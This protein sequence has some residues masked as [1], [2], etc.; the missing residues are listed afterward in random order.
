MSIIIN[1]NYEPTSSAAIAELVNKFA[2]TDTSNHFTGSQYL[3]D[4]Y[5]FEGSARKTVF[6]KGIFFANQLINDGDIIH[7]A[8]YY[9]PINLIKHTDTYLTTDN[10]VGRFYAPFDMTIRNL[11][12]VIKEF[13]GS[14]YVEILNLNTNLFVQVEITGVIS[15]NTINTLLA[16][17]NDPLIFRLYGESFSPKEVFISVEYEQIT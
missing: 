7:D 17:E 16:S 2:R 6:Q 11:K 1:P 3:G 4:A 13:S 10:T 12:V 9:M 8:D 15:T 5:V 14:A